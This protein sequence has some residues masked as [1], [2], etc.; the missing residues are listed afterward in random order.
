MRCRP[1]PRLLLLCLAPEA[2]LA[3]AT[4][5]DS[6]TIEEIVVVATKIPRPAHTV[7]AAVSTFDRG[8][9]EWEQARDLG[10]LAR[11]EPSL[12]ADYSS[13]RFGDSGIAIR[14]IGGNRVA[15]EFDGVPLPQQ[16]AV[17]SFA[18][19]S[20]LTVDSAIVG[21]AEVLRGPASALYGSDAIG[22]VIALTSTD[23]RDLISPGSSRHVAARGGYFG[24]DDGWTG[25]AT[26]AWAGAGDGLLA[27]GIYRAGNEPENRARGVPDDEIDTRQWQAFG[28]WTHDFDDGSGLEVS[29]DYFRR[30]TDSDTQ[31][32]LGSGRFVNST[33]ILGDDIQES[34][35]AA[36]EFSTSGFAGLEEGLVRAYWQSNDT[37]Q[38]TDELR[39]TGPAEQLIE[40][41]FTM[42][43]RD[44]GGEIR[45]RWDFATGALSHVLLVGGDWD[46]QNLLQR[47][48]GLQTRTAT[49]NTT[50]GATCPSP[51]SMSWVSISRT[52]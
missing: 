21:R 9:M 22:G 17:G 16:F 29:G 40:R 1:D 12:E 4:V 13:P 2:A 51:P 5:P 41:D 34:G 35:R 42:E 33:S 14:G 23:P 6:E 19:S 31:S 47:R 15:L 37:S 44:W 7:A 25:D 39:F 48:D 20:R 26:A 49:G 43:E 46:R 32:V 8:R 52:N 10:D 18:D 30:D 11:Y 45:G 27:S 36:A 24:V 3:A 28:K 50:N 38:K